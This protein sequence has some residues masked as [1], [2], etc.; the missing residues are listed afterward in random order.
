MTLNYSIVLNTIQTSHFSHPWL[1][2]SLTGKKKKKKEFSF[3]FKFGILG[4]NSQNLSGKFKKKLNLRNIL[5][6]KS[7]PS[8]NKQC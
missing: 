8:A 4:S 2:I 3:T 7:E 6:S 1:E 5:K